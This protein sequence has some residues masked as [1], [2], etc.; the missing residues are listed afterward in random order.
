MRTSKCLVDTLI[1]KNARNDIKD[2]FGRTPSSYANTTESLVPLPDVGELQGALTRPN[3][4]E[5]S[6]RRHSDMG[7]SFMS[8]SDDDMM[9]E[10]MTNESESED[11]DSEM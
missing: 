9:L 11:S 6:F 7:I 10:V 3:L 1:A 4:G 5:I 8:D 2:K